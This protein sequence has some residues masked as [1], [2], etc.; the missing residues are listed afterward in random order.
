MNPPQK[1]A[2]A[3][4]GTLDELSRATGYPRAEV[5]KQIGNLRRSGTRIRA[6]M[7]ATFLDDEGRPRWEPTVYEVA[8]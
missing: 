7:G 1:V 6:R 4:P 8:E 3:L 5:I 2:A